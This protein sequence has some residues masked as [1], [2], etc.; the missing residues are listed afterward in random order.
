MLGCSLRRLPPPSAVSQWRTRCVV[1]ARSESVAEP[2]G[3]VVDGHVVDD[4]PVPDVCRGTGGS[5]GEAG[6]GS[7]GSE[8]NI[9]GWQVKISQ[10]SVGEGGVSAATRVSCM[11]CAPYW[12][13]SSAARYGQQTGCP[14]TACVISTDDAASLASADHRHS[15]RP[16][17]KYPAGILH[18]VWSSGTCNTLR[19]TVAAALTGRGGACARL[20]PRQSRWPGR[21]AGR[22]RR[23]ARSCPHRQRRRQAVAADLPSSADRP[24]TLSCA[25]RSSYVIRAG[26]RAGG[27]GDERCTHSSSSTAWLG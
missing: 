16:V 11:P 27:A 4:H 19:V 17:R 2:N 20:G 5:G 3:S 9:F 12:P 23:T 13:V 25:A 24:F 7:A 22:R 10:G 26:V 8:E 14:E 18:R 15:G 1:S 6:G 21:A